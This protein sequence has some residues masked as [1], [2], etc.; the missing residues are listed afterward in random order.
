MINEVLAVNDTAFT[1]EEMFAGLSI[2]VTTNPD[3]IELRNLSAQVIDLSGYSVSD[4]PG[5]PTRWSIADG[6]T[7]APN[8]FVVIFATGEG[9]FSI[10]D[11]SLE[12]NFRLSAGGETIVLSDPSGTI[13]Q[14]LTYPQ[15]S[16]DVSYGRLDDG[17]YAFMN[18]ATIGEANDESSVS[19][20]LI[21]RPRTDQE[22]GLFP[23]NETLV[24]NL[25][26]APG[27][28]IHFTVDGSNPTA[29]SPIYSSPLSLT[30]TT[31]LKSIAIEATSGRASD[32]ASRSFIFTD[33]QHELP[34]VI[35]TPDDFR[36]IDGGGSTYSR[37]EFD[38]R[39]RLDFIETD[40]TLPISQYSEYERSG[41]F[42]VGTP[43]F[44]GKINATTR[45]GPSRLRHQFFLEKDENSFER[46]L[47][48]ASSQ[49]FGRLRLRD[50]IVSRIISD[51][52]IVDVEHEG[53]RPVVAYVNGLYAGHMNMREDD[54]PAFARQYFDLP[55]PFQDRA[56]SVSI[57]AGTM[58]APYRRF[59]NTLPNR[60][61]PDAI[62]RLNEFVRINE[63][64]L[65]AVLRD[66]LQVFEESIFWTS[67]VPG[68]QERYSLHDYDFAFDVTG[69]SAANR[70]VW[71]TLAWQRATEFPM[72]GENT[73]FWHDALQS[74]AAYLNLLAYPERLLRI[75][76][77][78]AD[79]I[80]SE[81]PRTTEVFES[82]RI[83]GGVG[84]GRRVVAQDLMEWEGELQ[85]VLD[86]VVERF[87]G[88]IEAMSANYSIPTVE[89]NIQSSDVTMGKVTAQ[90]YRVTSGREAGQ[91]FQNLPLR[92]EATA[93]PGFTF[94]G[95]TGD[96]P[97]GADLSDPYLE[98]SFSTN[99]AIVATF[100]PSSFTLAVSEIHYN[101]VGT[102]EEGEFIELINF[103]TEEIDLTGVSFS[104]GIQYAF[105]S[106]TV[107]S[108]GERIVVA[109]NQYN[110]ALN[111]DGERISL[112]NSS[113][114]VFEFFEYNDAIPWPQAAD[115]LGRSLVRIAPGRDEPNL[116]ASWRSSTSDGGNA[117]GSDSL[118][119]T[120]TSPEGLLN[121]A[122][123]GG[124]PEI[125]ISG[126]PDGTLS[127]VY[128]RVSNAD[129]VDIVLQS[130]PDLLPESW[131]TAPI[132]FTSQEILSDGLTSMVSEMDVDEE[133]LF[134][135]LEV[136]AR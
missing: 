75:V 2:T 112:S 100:A 67:E 58:S 71:D 52:D 66:S 116:P 90:G 1:R 70:G 59:A 26:S 11:V 74:A 106:N 55:E 101:P 47:L 22:S 10:G 32:I 28:Q 114:E 72:D 133:T 98:V 68:Q 135:R 77:Q 121:Y 81:I 4:D 38:G 48:R 29:S 5:N 9:E 69:L 40:G 119:L 8:G 15:Q 31:V 94:S 120:D 80:R 54:D 105:P 128:D 17:S 44:N 3:V 110:G 130:S 39:V 99:S 92:L 25:T 34:V 30:E 117:G 131:A 73:R 113:G 115:G 136:T 12:T 82:R 43:F 60:N 14:E 78:T 36:I 107:L 27:T 79:E 41:A 87:T 104:D 111:N 134:F 127:L 35:V 109:S 86:Y 126:N 13:I 51:G 89:V 33:V 64:M 57:R 122:F 88:A 76:N 95:W 97:T 63:A 56:D 42:S 16:A 96:V 103:G 108:A 7:I 46:I 129:A 123:G 6:V 91:Y 132:A 50:A 49:D 85:F 61:A 37:F 65:D 18:R 21:L 83:D 53:F 20:D 45:F 93:E 62:V 19:G 124:S 84:S 118:P 102:S 24:V 125:E 23:T